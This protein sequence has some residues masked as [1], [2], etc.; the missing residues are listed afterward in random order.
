MKQNQRV[1]IALFACLVLWCGWQSRLSW[2][3]SHQ[4]ESHKT[5]A[6]K[7]DNKPAEITPEEQI[8]KYTWW[9][10][11]LTG[12]LVG[13]AGIQ[14]YFLLR[15][16]KTAR[17][18]AEAARKSA[19]VIPNIERPYVFVDAISLNNM[20]T[21]IPLLE[22]RF[23]NYG[24]TPANIAEVVIYF[25]ILDHLPTEADIPPTKATPAEEAEIIIAAD[26]SWTSPTC[27]CFDKVDGPIWA[28]ARA[29]DLSI[30]AWGHIKYRDVFGNT[31]PTISVENTVTR[32]A[33][34][35][36]LAA[37]RETKPLKPMVPTAAAQARQRPERLRRS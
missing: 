7:T 6:D 18:T 31:N 37:W 24:R 9:L 22:I 34:G 13:V 15:S 11:L 27:W 1:A 28:K 19:D 10:A 29:G 14:G 25:R 2:Q 3:Q 16:D 12:C 20:S 23:H 17:I 5:S 4:H 8:A 21:A 33:I 35:C 30:Y 36:P 32:S 26:K